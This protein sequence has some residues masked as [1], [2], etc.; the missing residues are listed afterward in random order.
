M[1]APDW[2]PLLTGC[3]ASNYTASELRTKLAATFAVK[4]AKRNSFIQQ[5]PRQG[6]KTEEERGLAQHCRHKF[7][8]PPRTPL[9]PAAQV[10]PRLSQEHRMIP[11]GEGGLRMRR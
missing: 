7:Q 8:T 6:H 9:A 5:N 11:C 10:A 3:L 4:G 1:A 2:S